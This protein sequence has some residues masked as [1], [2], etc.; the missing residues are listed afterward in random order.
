MRRERIRQ[1]SFL[2]AKKK[3]TDKLAYSVGEF[4][5]GNKRIVIRGKADGDGGLYGDADK[6]PENA[7]IRF[8]E[9][10]DVF[11]KFGGGTK[12]LSDHFT[13]LK[14]PLRLRA[15]IPLIASGNDVLVIFGVGISDKIR[16]DNA[17]KNVISFTCEEL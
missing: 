5:L 17:T 4:I 1:N 10:G 13:D 3:L 2:R 11:K 6:I 8:K 7:V 16:V 15:N 12:K 9:D 14:I